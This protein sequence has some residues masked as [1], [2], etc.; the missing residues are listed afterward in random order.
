M[1]Q[2]SGLFG[3]LKQLLVQKEKPRVAGNDAVC[4]ETVQWHHQRETTTSLED[5]TYQTSTKCPEF[6]LHILPKTHP[7]VVLECTG[8]KPKLVKSWSNSSQDIFSVQPEDD[9]LTKFIDSCC[10]GNDS[11]PNVIHYIWYSDKEMSYFFFL[12]FMSA[13][14]FVKPCLFVIHGDLLP[15]GR[16]WDYCVSQAPNIIHV[17]RN[18]TTRIFNQDVPYFEFSSDVMRI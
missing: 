8:D 2:E 13:L 10:T 16:Y 1:H 17:K 3:S 5:W 11:V 9:C 4:E 15:R 6:S 7:K 18:R 12:S 14:R